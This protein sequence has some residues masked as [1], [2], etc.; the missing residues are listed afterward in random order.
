VHR[1][2]RY[3]SSEDRSPSP[4]PPGP[5]V[6]SKAIRETILLARFCP[7]PRLS[8]STTARPNLNFGSLIS[9]WH[10]SWVGPLMTGSLF[11]NSPCPCQTPLEPGSRTFHLDRSTTGMTS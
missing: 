9:A 6:F 3:D 8:P 10:V 2:G 11:D 1:G 4:E 5:R 7:P